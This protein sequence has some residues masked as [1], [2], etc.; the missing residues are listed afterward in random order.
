M[1]TGLPNFKNKV[2]SVVCRGEDTGQLICNP[3]FEKQGHRLFI[4]GTVPK[5]ASQD[6][7]MEGLT[8]AIAW[9]TVQDSRL[10]IH[11]LL[12][13]LQGTPSEVYWRDRKWPE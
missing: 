10:K 4:V 2:L 8:C 5:D 7:W 13:S 11:Y 1:K 9:D 12:Q 3:S 6:N